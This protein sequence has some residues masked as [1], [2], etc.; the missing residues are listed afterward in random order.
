MTK[1]KIQTKFTKK[2]QHK[3]MKVSVI[4]T[5]ADA[6]IHEVYSTFKNNKNIPT[7]ELEIVLKYKQTKKCKW[8]IIIWRHVQN[9]INKKQKH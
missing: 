4:D 3:T 5:R 2:F 6:Y 9:L 7:K 8:P 1:C